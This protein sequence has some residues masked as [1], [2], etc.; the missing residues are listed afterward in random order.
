MDNLEIERRF[1]IFKYGEDYKKYPV[2]KIIQGY[3]EISGNSHKRVR[4]VDSKKAFLTEKIGSGISRQEIEQPIKI[5]EGRE[6]LSGCR[7]I[8]KKNRYFCK[9][10]WT[11]DFFL[12]K[13]SRIVIAEKELTTTK[14]KISL[15]KWIYSY[16]EVTD[17]F[18]SLDLAMIYPNLHLPDKPIEPIELVRKILNE[19]AVGNLS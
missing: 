17:L 8:I 12:G 10:G 18:S 13:L 5:K 19:K 16:D 14:E 15:P 1:L 3:F 7:Y 11:V 6:I 4:I 9:D 2:S